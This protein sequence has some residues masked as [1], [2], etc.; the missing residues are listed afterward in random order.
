VRFL[1]TDRDPNKTH[2]LAQW[3]REYLDEQEAQEKYDTACANA[4]KIID[5]P[6][7]PRSHN[8]EAARRIYMNRN[9]KK[10]ESKSTSQ[11][12]VADTLRQLIDEKY[13]E[14]YRVERDGNK[15]TVELADMTRFEFTVKVTFY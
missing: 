5:A 9:Q 15:I 6:Q 10:R 3:E 14:S 11:I 4:Q 7:M 8:G 2:T 13:P 12:I 1:V